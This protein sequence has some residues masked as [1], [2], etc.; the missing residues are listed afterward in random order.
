MIQKDLDGLYRPTPFGTLVLSQL[1]GLDFA[2]KQREYFL[3]YD[4]SGL[5]YEF[6]NRLGELAGGRVFSETFR[7]LEETARRLGEA[8]EYVWI[9]S[10]QNFKLFAPMMVEKLKSSFDLR[11][12]F[13][14]TA[15]YPERVAPI[16]SNVPGMQKR[17]LPSLG[18]RVVLTE[19]VAGLSLPHSRNKL[20]FRALMGDDVRF[21]KWCKDLFLYYWSMAKPFIS[22]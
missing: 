20:D 12:I 13:P 18:F 5:P 11:T 1:S 16:P 19:K 2:S 9:L 14:E 21:H 7:T 6:V 22:G 3:E 17:V 8:Q 4:V 10:D 15:Y